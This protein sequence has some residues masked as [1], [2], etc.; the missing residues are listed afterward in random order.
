MKEL[1]DALDE[2]IALLGDELNEMAGFM[3]VHGWQSHRVEQGIELREKID[4]LRK[5]VS[6]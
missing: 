5:E 6:K 4:R 3:H 2:Y 1:I